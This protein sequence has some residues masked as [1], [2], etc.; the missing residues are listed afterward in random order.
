MLTAETTAH[1]LDRMIRTARLLTLAAPFLL[2][3]FL[4]PSAS[5]TFPGTNGLIAFSQGDLFPS[6]EGDLSVRSQVFTI[7]PATDTVRR[8]TNVP[9]GD[10]AAAP[11]WSADGTKIVYESRRKGRF[12][13]WVMNADGSGQKRLTGKDGFDDFLPS[14]SRDGSRILYSHCSDPFDIDFF[15]YCDIDR[16]NADG[17]SRRRVLHSG[18]WINLRAE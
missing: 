16:M 6:R 4:V 5:A 3:A 18:N 8:L 9:K 1:R 12:E 7:D 10:A 15:A 14:F 2:G 17:T 11:D 13:I